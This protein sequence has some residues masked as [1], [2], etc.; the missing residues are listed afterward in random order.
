M[1]KGKYAGIGKLLRAVLFLL[2]FGVLFCTV[3]YIL[4]PYSGSASRKNLCGFYAEEDNTLDIVCIGSS[5][6]FTFW[7]PMEFWH[8]YG[9]TSYNFATGTMPPQVIKY[10]IKEIQKTQN[11]SLYI[12]DLRPFSVAEAGYYLKREVANM[13]HEVPLRNVTDNFKYSLN[14]WDMIRNCVPD[15][16]DRMTYYLDILKYHSEWNRLVDTQSLL[17]ARNDAHDS[18]KG[19]KLVPSA[20]AVKFADHSDDENRQPLSERLEPIFRDLLDYCKEED[21]QVL[22]LVNTYCQ[23]KAHKE[24]YNYAGDIIE[25]YGFDFLN[26]NDYYQEIGMDFEKDYYDKSHVN[27]FGADK[28]TDFVGKYLMENYSFQDKRGLEAYSDW[29]EDYAIWTEQVNELKVTVQGLIDAM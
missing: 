22:F 11:P 7:E 9:V 24:M 23:T 5:A 2:L 10:C 28:Y 21:L 12:I 4:R 20:K 18:L 17:F 26:T 25:E 19:F 16:E 27:I 29:D 8:D 15:F 6:V 3:S 1:M 14:R 13:D